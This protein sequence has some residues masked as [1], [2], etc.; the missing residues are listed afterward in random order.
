MNYVHSKV[1]RISISPKYLTRNKAFKT[2]KINSC[3][4]SR[5]CKTALVSKIVIADFLKP[6]IKS[7]KVLYILKRIKW[8][9]T[10]KTHQTLNY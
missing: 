10:S 6:K 8:L 7:N 4:F 5:V 1:F 3:V 2:K 9:V